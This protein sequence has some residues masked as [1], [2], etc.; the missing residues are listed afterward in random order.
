M[1]R[2]CKTLA[3]GYKCAILDG[4]EGVAD[5]GSSEIAD[6][7]MPTTKPKGTCEKPWEVEYKS[8]IGGNTIDDLYSACEL[9]NGK[10]TCAARTCT[11][12]GHFV[13][14]LI[15]VIMQHGPIDQYYF[16]RHGDFD[17]DKNGVCKVAAV[18]NRPDMTW[19]TTARP[20]ALSN[21]ESNSLFNDNDENQ[22]N[23]KN[24]WGALDSE[25]PKQPNVK[26]CCGTYPK[27]HSYM[28]QYGSKSCCNKRTFN[29]EFLQCCDN[30]HLKIKGSC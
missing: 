30:K 28:T 27:R 16:H 10:N 26:K 2:V 14:D 9:L 12:E 7:K 8:A 25:Q 5:S 4:R 19:T 1:D 6:A 18:E 17:P 29:T 15:T 13:S 11:I 3:Q 23:S 24:D 20:I 21:G 22:D